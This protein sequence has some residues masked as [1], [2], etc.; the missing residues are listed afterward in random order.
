LSKTGT[1][2][3]RIELL[4]GGKPAKLCQDS[5]I[6]NDVAKMRRLMQGSLLPSGTLSGFSLA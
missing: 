2:S 6:A 1:V 5:N 3:S 4:R